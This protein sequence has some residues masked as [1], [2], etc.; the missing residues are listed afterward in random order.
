MTPN[1]SNRNRSVWLARLAGEPYTDI[2]RRH[3]ITRSR[4]QQIARNTQRAVDRALQ[5]SVPI[6]ARS[7]DAYG[8]WH[9]F[10]PGDVYLGSSVD[11]GAAPTHVSIPSPPPL[12]SRP[13]PPPAKWIDWKGGYAPP[14]LGVKVEYKLRSGQVFEEYAEGLLWFHDGDQSDIVAY[15]ST[16]GS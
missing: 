4:A 7:T 6:A 13:A 5:Q 11:L 10:G 9:H 14:L 1:R 3:G 15:R 16:E 8:V 2:G 12:E